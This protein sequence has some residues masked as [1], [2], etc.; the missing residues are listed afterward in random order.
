MITVREYFDKAR[1]MAFP[2]V[3]RRGEISSRFRST[4]TSSPACVGGKLA[5]ALNAEEE[6]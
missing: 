5:Y 1:A 4:L 6:R 3:T 2:V